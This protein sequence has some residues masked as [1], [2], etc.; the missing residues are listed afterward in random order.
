MPRTAQAPHEIER[1]GRHHESQEHTS[2][3]PS[4]IDNPTNKA[5][6]VFSHNVFQGWLNSQSP[7]DPSALA[8]PSK[9]DQKQ[10]PSDQAEHPFS[11]DQSGPSDSSAA[12]D[13]QIVILNALV[14]FQTLSN[15]QVSCLGSRKSSVKEDQA[16]LNRTYISFAAVVDSPTKS[17]RIVSRCGRYKVVTDLSINSL[18]STLLRRIRGVL[19][20]K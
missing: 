2:P 12:C 17:L 11:R 19:P 15:F 4:A 16:C 9:S 14:V 10:K 8:E 13:I 1:V 6:L 5:C 18:R 7:Q 3:S 20:R